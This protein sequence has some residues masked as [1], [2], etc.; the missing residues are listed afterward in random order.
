VFERR[1]A[2]AGA[3]IS[4]GHDGADGTRSLRIGEVSGWSL[5]QVEAFATTL[6]D[7]EAAVRPMLNADLPDRI[8]GVVNVHSRRL[9]KTGPNQFWIISHDHDD[10]TSMLQAAVA[11]G[12]GA[13]TSLSHSRTCIFIEGVPARKL[14]ARGIALD[15]HS[16]VFRLGQFALTGLH[17]TP[18]LIHRS[19]EN[20]YELYVMR[21]FALSIWDWLAD[22]A[23]P[24]GYEIAAVG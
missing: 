1:S 13:V 16:K 24:F 19:G 23:L 17:H 5:A 6:S 12:V 20:R 8:G 9:L 18:V 3:L 2:L 14:L 22:A 7:L 10:L 11:P 21:T 15:F 4:S